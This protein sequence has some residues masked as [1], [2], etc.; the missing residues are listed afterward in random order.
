MYVATF[1]CWH[2]QDIDLSYFSVVINER[3][4]LIKLV[5]GAIAFAREMCPGVPLEEEHVPGGK[6][7][8]LMDGYELGV[9]VWSFTV[10]PLEVDKIYIAEIR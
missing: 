10:A 8:W 3:S 5:D 2:S 9:A 1:E 7:S 4:E 6:S